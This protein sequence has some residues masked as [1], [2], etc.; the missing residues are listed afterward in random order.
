MIITCSECSTSFKLDDSLIKENG[1]KVRC[2]VCK[3]IFTAFPL[4]REP[5]QG[6]I[7]TSDIIPESMPDFNPEE[8]PDFD[9]SSDFDTGDTDF[10]MEDSDLEIDQQDLV[11]EDQ[12]DLVLEDTEFTSQ[13][14]DLKD[15]DITFDEDEFELNAG[16]EEKEPEEKDFEFETENISVEADENKDSEFDGIDFEPMEDE[17]GDLTLSM[18]ED[19]DI[20]A[21]DDR[22]LPD[23]DFGDDELHGKEGDLELE[24]ATEETE[25]E[26]ELEFDVSDDPIDDIADE[27]DTDTD[28]SPLE[29]MKDPEDEAETT[30]SGNTEPDDDLAE[31]TPEDNFAE[32]DA[33]LAQETEPE[34]DNSDDEKDDETETNNGNFTQE[35]SL[36]EKSAPLMDLPER[37]SRRKKKP[38]VSL[39]V[40]LLLMIFLVVAGAYVASIMTGYKI[41]YLPEVNLPFIE[42]YLK[43]AVPAADV[44][45]VPNESSVNGRFVSNTAGGTLFVITGRVDNISNLPF[46]HVEVQ[47]T[48][49]TKEN[50]AAKT[51]NAFCGN[52]ITEEML[53]SGNIAEILKLLDVKEGN[54]N[55]NV[56]I[57]P[58][59]S[60]PFMIVFSDLPEKLQNFNVK[61]V[62]FTKTPVN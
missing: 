15:T 60:V 31:I 48:L 43:K 51:K 54:H 28:K 3:H 61:V 5:E 32:Y 42:K 58:G 7:E 52:I 55:T 46:S 53:L 16:N 22:N 37:R 47:G 27:P 57:K 40:M 35:K 21:E 41:P 1:S 25:E 10:S 62:G 44:K 2:S 14:L 4:S 17:S 34:E 36:I 49:S 30:D 23:T 39:P 59:A 45:P 11:L 18:E 24:E 50:P 29:I 26:F 8:P 19:T 13:D 20:N 12:Q 9:D 33:V 6:D 38:L 56:N